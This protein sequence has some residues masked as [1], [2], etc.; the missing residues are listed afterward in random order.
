VHD[1]PGPFMVGRQTIRLA[2]RSHVRES[3]FGLSFL[4]SPTAFFQTNVEATAVLLDEVTRAIDDSRNGHGPEPL[5]ILDLYAGSGL[6]ALT[7]AA[8]GHRVTAVEENHDATRDAVANRRLNRLPED[9]VRIVTGRVEEVLPRLI[10]RGFEAAIIDPPRQGCPRRVLDDVF[11][12]IA[13]RRVV[14]VSCNASALAEELPRV[15]RSGYEIAR[16]QP[17]DMF[18]HT[19]HIE[20]V[21]TLLQR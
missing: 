11:T 18:P 7:L 9:S 19:D 6:F 20:T 17:V 16:V 13:P 4:I 12:A 3:R 14:Y 2:G 10:R 1:R 5:S 15:V 21:V 8:R